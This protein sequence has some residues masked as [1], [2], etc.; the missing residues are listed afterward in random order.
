MPE[1]FS[2]PDATAIKGGIGR[3]LLVWFAE[4]LW[5]AFKIQA[6]FLMFAGYSPWDPCTSCTFTYTL[7]TVCMINVGRHRYSFSNNHGSGTWSVWRVATHL[8]GI[9]VFPRLGVPQNGWFIMENPIKMDDLGGTILGNPHI[10]QSTRK[11]LDFYPDPNLD[12]YQPGFRIYPSEVWQLAL[13]KWP[14]NPIGSRIVFLSHHFTIF[15]GE[16]SLLNFQGCTHF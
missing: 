15:P 2:K 6:V 9:W 3:M 10:T 1:C 8:P 12:S 4:N 11:L 16:N 7:F 5:A 13:E 14:K